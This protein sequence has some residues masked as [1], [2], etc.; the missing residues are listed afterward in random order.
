[1]FVVEQKGLVGL[2]YSP[3]SPCKVPF[4]VGVVVPPLPVP[5][6]PLWDLSRSLLLGSGI[7]VPE[8]SGCNLS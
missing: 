8:F 5:D 4:V 2:P 6:L 3:V 7:V 1:M